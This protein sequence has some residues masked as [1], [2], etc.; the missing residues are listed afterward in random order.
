MGTEM[1]SGVLGVPIRKKRVINLQSGD[2]M[3]PAVEVGAA[4]L[5]A[6]GLDPGASHGG[7]LAINMQQ[8]V[9]RAMAS[10]ACSMR[11]QVRQR[12]V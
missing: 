8:D 4:D 5:E 1:A 9:E 10:L 6:D 11:V 3:V 7:T 12:N 2:T